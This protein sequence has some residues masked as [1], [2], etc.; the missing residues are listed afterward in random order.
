MRKTHQPERRADERRTLARP[1][2]LYNP[3]TGKYHQARTLDISAGGLCL[4]VDHPQ[5]LSHGQP[6]EVGVA[7]S[8]RN[9]VLNRAELIG[10]HVVRSLGLGGSQ[11]VAVQFQQRQQMAA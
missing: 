11:R 10:G 4:Q 6:V 2:K 7:W 3:L 9:V 5:A 8:A 1:A